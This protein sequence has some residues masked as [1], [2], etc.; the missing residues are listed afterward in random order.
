MI[1]A[2]LAAIFVPLALISGVLGVQ[3]LRDHLA[4]RDLNT[5]LAHPLGLHNS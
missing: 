4:H 2:I 5:A 3:S 1:Q